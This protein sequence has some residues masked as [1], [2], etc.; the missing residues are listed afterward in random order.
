MKTIEYWSR[1]SSG[2]SKSTG[3]LKA[4]TDTKFIVLSG[5]YNVELHFPKKLYTYKIVEDKK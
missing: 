5:R 2:S 4:E 3:L 1:D